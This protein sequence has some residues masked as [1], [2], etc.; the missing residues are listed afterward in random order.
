MTRRGIRVPEDVRIVGIDNS[1]ASPFNLVP[2]TS[3]SQE[4]FARGRQAVQ[5]LLDAVAGKTISSVLLEPVLHIRTSSRLEV[6]Q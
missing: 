1:P 6:R 4:D 3:V 2:L 5:M